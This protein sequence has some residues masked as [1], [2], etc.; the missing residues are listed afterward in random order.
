MSDDVE[1]AYE[2]HGEGEPILLIHGFA[3][4]GKVN[5]GS[6][7]WIE[8]L[9]RAGRQAIV[10][11]NRG[12]GKSTKLHDPEL[13]ALVKNRMRDQFILVSTDGPEDNIIKMKPPL[14]FT[15]ENAD[16]VVKCMEGVLAK[17]WD[18]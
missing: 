13:A 12:H 6:T 7:G 3:S 4:N 1:I 11:D 18:G 5:W 9:T 8:L 15:R 14:C 16:A 2:V 10:I 17:G